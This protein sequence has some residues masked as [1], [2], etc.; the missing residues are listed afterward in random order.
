LIVLGLDVETT[1]LDVENDSII[2]LG[3]VLWCTGENKPLAIY[4]SL[5]KKD[6]VEVSEEITRITGITNEHISKYGSIDKI[7]YQQLCE[8]ALL[9]RPK[10][11]VAHNGNDFDRPILFNELDRSG[12]NTMSLKEIPWI[13]TRNDLPFEIEPQSNKLMHLALDAGFINPFPHRAFADVL[14]MLKVMS[15]FGFEEILEYRDT[16]SVE[17]RAMV[18]FDNKE[19]AKSQQFRWDANRKI[20][21]K[22]IKIHLLYELEQKCDF[23][24]MA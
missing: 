19:K 17:I 8:V 4:N 13:D 14:T 11:I 3:V 18:N 1:G 12:I 6:G 9:H 10:Y 5:I 16:P 2:E 7:V 24:I 15:Q 21:H 22:N 23:E 20:W